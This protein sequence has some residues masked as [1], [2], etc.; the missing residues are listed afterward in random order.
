MSNRGLYQMV[1]NEENFFNKNL[2]YINNI[3]YYL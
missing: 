2:N 1:V 3:E